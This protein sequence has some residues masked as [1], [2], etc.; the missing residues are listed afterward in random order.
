M[1]AANERKS[2]LSEPGT[3]LPRGTVLAIKLTSAELQGVS[4]KLAP[5]YSGPWTVTRALENGTTYCVQDPVTL[6]EKQVPWDR[7]NMLQLQSETVSFPNNTLPCWTDTGTYRLKT[8]SIDRVSEQLESLRPEGNLS[9]V[10]PREHEQPCRKTPPLTGEVKKSTSGAEPFREGLRWTLSRRAGAAP[11]GVFVRARRGR[12]AGAGGS[13]KMVYRVALRRYTIGHS[14][15]PSGCSTISTSINRWGDLDLQSESAVIALDFGGVTAAP[16]RFGCADK[17]CFTRTAHAGQVSLRVEGTATADGSATGANLQ[18]RRAS[19]NLVSAS[20]ILAAF[21]ALFLI[22]QC[23]RSLVLG[24]RG[25][26]TRRL[27]EGNGGFCGRN[28]EVRGEACRA[29]LDELTVQFQMAALA[30]R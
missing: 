5:R 2:L 16:E 13:D 22:I 21:A 7:V 14:T 23:H 20:A 11:G 27:G 3:I 9:W 29:A 28:G 30:R 4:R 1:K 24:N 12:R 8:S 26:S 6:G 17:D 10:E 25:K 19:L 18:Q 15:G